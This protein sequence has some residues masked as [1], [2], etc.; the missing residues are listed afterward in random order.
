MVYADGFNLYYRMLEK[1]PDLK[2]LNIKQ[3]AEKASVARMER[4]VIRVSRT[5]SHHPGFCFAPSGLLA[6]VV[7]SEHVLRD[8]KAARKYEVHASLQV[9]V[10]IEAFKNREVKFN[11]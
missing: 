4:S 9:K 10:A 6:E 11:F 8:Q 7:D 1:R 3:V 5:Q 2:W